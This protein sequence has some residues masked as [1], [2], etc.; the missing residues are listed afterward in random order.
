MLT[1]CLYLCYQDLKYL[2]HTITK[3]STSRSVHFKWMLFEIWG[4]RQRDESDIEGVVSWIWTVNSLTKFI[5]FVVHYI[6]S[7]SENE[8]S[9]KKLPKSKSNKERP[10]IYASFM[11]PTLAK[12]P[13]K[14]HRN[15]VCWSILKQKS[16]KIVFSKKVYEHIL[17]ILIHFPIFVLYIPGLLT[18]STFYLWWADNQHTITNS[19]A[20]PKTRGTHHI[21]K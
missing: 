3:F 20:Q 7:Y 13:K 18:P 16:N 19:L 2:A 4:N 10:N 8:K 15:R 9:I 1:I 21:E 17:L 5:W 14:I 12:K 6:F 11:P